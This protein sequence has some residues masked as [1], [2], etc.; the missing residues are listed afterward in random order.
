MPSRKK[1]VEK[2]TDKLI[3]DKSISRKSQESNSACNSQFTPENW[4]KELSSKKKLRNDRQSQETA[5][6][7]LQRQLDEF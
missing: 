7:D 3:K 1:P 2:Q 4:H 5:I 6:L